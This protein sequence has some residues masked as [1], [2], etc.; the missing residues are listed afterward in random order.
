[1]LPLSEDLVSNASGGLF[2]LTQPD[3]MWSQT[4]AG[5]TQR[6]MA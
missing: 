1:V 3:H 6:L 4:A 2:S 5:V